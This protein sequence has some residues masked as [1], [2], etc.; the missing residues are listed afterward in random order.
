MAL[1]G[2][3]WGKYWRSGAHWCLGMGAAA[4][5]GGWHSPAERPPEEDEE[6]AS[7]LLRCGLPPRDVGTLRLC[8][9][10][11]GQGPELVMGRSVE[12]L[13]LGRQP[14]NSSLPQDHPKNAP[15]RAQPNSKNVPIDERRGEIKSTTR[16]THWGVS[17]E[18]RIRTDGS[19]NALKSH[20]FRECQNREN[21]RLEI[22]KCGY[23]SWA[24]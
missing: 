24:I 10:K 8:L 17:R 9:P 18:L 20:T 16:G 21:P 12:R 19:L 1:L 11:F 4:N 5:S 3:C 23:A 22:K 13:P 7:P 15:P 14:H 2:S 6:G